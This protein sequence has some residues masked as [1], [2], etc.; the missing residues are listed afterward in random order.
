[1]TAGKKRG[2]TVG[3]KSGEETYELGHEVWLLGDSHLKNMHH[4]LKG[5]SVTSISGGRLEHARLNLACYRSLIQY[6][7]LFLLIGGNDLSHH[8]NGHQMY[9]SLESLVKWVVNRF[10]GLNVVT[11]TLVPRG[12]VGYVDASLFVDRQIQQASHNHHHFYHK[13]FIE[14]GFKRSWQI[15]R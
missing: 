8:V 15:Q 6:E 12:Q 7:T 13:L 11:G 2:L 10:P 3:M 1:M 4:K 14:R 9:S 5:V